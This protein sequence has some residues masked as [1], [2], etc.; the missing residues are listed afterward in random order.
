VLVV[1]RVQARA[2]QGAMLR[3]LLP[4]RQHVG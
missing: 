1:L 2:H 3:H 4:G